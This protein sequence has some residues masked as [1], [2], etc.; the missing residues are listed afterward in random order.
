MIIIFLSY[1][2][3]ISSPFDVKSYQYDWNWE[4]RGFGSSTL[5]FLWMNVQENKMLE[6][7]AICRGAN[8]DGGWVFR[9]FGTFGFTFGAAVPLLVLGHAWADWIATLP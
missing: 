7:Q 4:N 5:C 9:A 3:R 6:T 2:D 1:T 8:C